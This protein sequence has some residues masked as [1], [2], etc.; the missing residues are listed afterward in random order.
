VRRVADS[1]SILTC[2]RAVCDE[3]SADF[4]YSPDSDRSKSISFFNKGF[5]CFAYCHIATY[6]LECKGAGTPSPFSLHTDPPP[7]PRCII[8]LHYE[9]V[10]TF[11]SL[12]F[13]P[14]FPSFFMLGKR[15]WFLATM[16]VG[17]KLQG[18]FFSSF[19]ED[20]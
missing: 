20:G 15:L 18:F 2:Y 9:W 4:S 6:H 3:T 17:P 11:I 7:S 5:M 14:F 12:F 10:G 13:P 8:H 1:R 16:S 19:K